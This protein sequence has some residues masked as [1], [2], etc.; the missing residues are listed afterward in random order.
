MP[1]GHMLFKLVMSLT[2]PS[3]EVRVFVDKVIPPFQAR[4]FLMGNGLSKHMH[5]GDLSLLGMGLGF[6][7]IKMGYLRFNQ[8]HSLILIISMVFLDKGLHHKFNMRQINNENCMN[9]V[10]S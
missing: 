5:Q 7:D 1:L 8:N 10:H 6:L 9:F 2:C 3:I 4:V